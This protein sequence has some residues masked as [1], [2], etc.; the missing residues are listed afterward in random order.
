MREYF[1]LKEKLIENNAFVTAENTYEWNRLNELTIK[2]Q[3]EL[4]ALA[5]A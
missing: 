5:S 2:Y 3:N 1:E 4:Y